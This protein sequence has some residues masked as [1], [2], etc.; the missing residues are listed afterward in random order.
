M[1][2]RRDFINQP[3]SNDQGLGQVAFCPFATEYGFSLQR[4]QRTTSDFKY[5]NYLSEQAHI[6]GLE[7]AMHIR[8]FLWLSLDQRKSNR[9]GEG[10][11]TLHNINILHL[12]AGG[13]TQAAESL[14][15]LSKRQS[16]PPCA[17]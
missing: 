7:T 1:A 3:T 11:M 16:N 14:E 2:K 15:D 5:C 17:T 10:S 9:A 6:L 13:R 4:F 8:L 12:P